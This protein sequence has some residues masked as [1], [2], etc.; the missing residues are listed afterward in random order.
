MALI[1]EAQVRFSTLKRFPYEKFNCVN[2]FT[3][4]DSS[5]YIRLPSLP[6]FRHLRTFLFFVHYVLP[7]SFPPP[8]FQSPT[9]C[10]FSNSFY[11][12]ILLSFRHSMPPSL[13]RS[14][15]YSVSSL[16]FA[17]IPSLQLPAYSSFPPFH[18]I[19]IPCQPS[20]SRHVLHTL[21]LGRLDSEKEN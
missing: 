13:Q 12:P 6:P 7:L 11:L 5:T 18:S 4:M 2:T 3:H 17:P 16:P 14:M 19:S 1:S 20:P 8:S 9:C 15:Y 21:P 10:P